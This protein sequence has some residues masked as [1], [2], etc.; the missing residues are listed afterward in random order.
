MNRG[1]ILEYKKIQK[2][3][4]NL[5][6]IKTNRFKTISMRVSFKR[7]LKKEE[8]TLR[9]IV[10]DILLNTNKDYPKIRDIVIKTED[11]YNFSATST[12][13]KSGNYS[14]VSWNA[15]FLNEKYTEKGMNEESIRFFMNLLFN[16]NVVNYQFDTKA[17]DYTKEML[18]NTIESIKDNP[19]RYSQVRM[20]EIMYPDSVQS[21]RMDGYLEDLEEVNEENT[22]QYYQDM[23]KN[24]IVDIFVLGDFNIEEIENYLDKYILLDREQPKYKLSHIV[25]NEKTK[26]QIK[27]CKEAEKNNQSKLAIGLKLYNLD[28]FERKYTLQTLAFI[29]GGSGDSKLFKKVRGEN[30]LCYYIQASPTALYQNMTIT[31]GIDKN[32]YEKATQLIKETIQNIQ[33]GDVTDE[34]I[35]QGI[36][37]Y[38]NSCMEMYDSPSSIINTYLAQEYLG[39]DLI[40][41]RMRQIKKVTKEKVIALS[42]KMYIDTIYLLEGDIVDG[43]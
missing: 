42:K 30:S 11:L 24:D 41:E 7:P 28:D 9:N 27:V 13:Y 31:S 23:L 12:C 32:D 38:L 29:L 17:L 25:P 39:N 19:G 22:Y 35:E 34:E 8:I 10:T 6:F 16:P 36:N 1:E 26:E 14:I 37:T 43:K 2:K 15:S 40:E 20:K 4:F 5:H 18:K 21:Y 3:G 33:S